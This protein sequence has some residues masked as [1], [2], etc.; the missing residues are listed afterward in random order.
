[1]PY[2]GPKCRARVVPLERTGGIGV[3]TA[4]GIYPI[5]QALAAAGFEPGDLVEIRLVERE[6]QFGV[7]VVL[8][9]HPW[10]PYGSPRPRGSDGP[11][12]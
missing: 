6:P 4:E 2:S 12:W 7:K 11:G 1:M 9:D 10:G 5:G 3:R 8:P